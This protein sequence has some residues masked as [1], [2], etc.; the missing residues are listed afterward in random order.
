[1]RE[2]SKEAVED[3]IPYDYY[4]EEKK[5]YCYYPPCHICGSPAKSLVYIRDTKYTCE[6][7]RRKLIQ[8]RCHLSEDTSMMEK[9]K[10]L[11]RALNR[12]SRVSKIK[13][14]E[15]A[16]EKVRKGFANKNYYQS[17]EEI[18]VALELLRRGYVIY[19]QKEI[20]SFHVDFLIPELSVV[21]EVDGEP[22]H[23]TNKAKS[24]MRDYLIESCL[25]NGYKV[26]H[27]PTK[28]INKNVTKLVYAIKKIK[29]KDD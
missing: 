16:I 12:I 11:K 27:I 21:L 15:D 29:E 3:G 1:M 18:M 23:A 24:D 25:G 14:Y 10:R 17:T 22:F 13:Y 4:N 8:I 5:V 7:C 6:L 28:Y 2:L 19:H 26:V 9:E 20:A